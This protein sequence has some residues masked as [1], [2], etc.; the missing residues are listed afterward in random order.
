MRL[1]LKF[2]NLKNKD[3]L[4]GKSLLDLT[5]PDLIN[6]KYLDWYIKRGC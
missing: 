6:N 2:H 3:E 5:A 1:L 4:I